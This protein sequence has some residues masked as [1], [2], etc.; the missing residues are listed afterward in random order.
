MTNLEIVKSFYREMAQGGVSAALGLLDPAV[1]WL[2]AEMGIYYD[3][4]WVGPEAVKKNLFDKVPV[5]WDFFAI[6][7]ES[8]VAEGNVVVAF[9]DYS[10]KYSSTGKLFNAPFVHRWEVA[11]GK[12]TSFRQY[13]DTALQR[14]VLS[15]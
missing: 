9:G 4:T 1:K 3:G 10:G 5:D 2:E 7:P 6:T 15:K 8:F 14:Q 13:T 11:N 12:L